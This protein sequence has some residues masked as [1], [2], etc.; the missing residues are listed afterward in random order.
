[1]P[2]VISCLTEKQ[3]VTIKQ[4][5][6]W[7]SL[8]T[9]F[10]FFTI[11]KLFIFLNPVQFG[12]KCFFLLKTYKLKERASLSLSQMNCLFFGH[13]LLSLPFLFFLRFFTLGIFLCSKNHQ[14]PLCKCLMMH[15]NA[16]KTTDIAEYCSWTLREQIARGK[17]YLP[18]SRE[19]HF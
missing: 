3:S 13:P 14:R 16:N 1:M 9:L 8:S 7:S 18:A 11:H 4:S 5:L 10:F 12:W 6:S 17:H 15:A 2:R 19:N